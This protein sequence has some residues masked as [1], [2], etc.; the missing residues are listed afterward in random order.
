M[1]NV[2]ASVD[3]ISMREHPG[4][5]PPPTTRALCT[6]ATTTL[7]SV[8]STRWPVTLTKSALSAACLPPFG[9]VPSTVPPFGGIERITSHGTVTVIETGTC[10]ISGAVTSLS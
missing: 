9:A 3:V 7:R 5:P 2:P 8:M 4:V 1:A 6:L 10:E